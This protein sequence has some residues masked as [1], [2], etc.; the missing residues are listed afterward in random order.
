MHKGDDAICGGIILNAADLL[1]ML[2]ND[3]FFAN[4]YVYIIPMHK[5]SVD[6]FESPE[7]IVTTVQVHEVDDDE[8]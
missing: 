6:L 1:N 7:D 5:T 8:E 3:L 2:K 4:P